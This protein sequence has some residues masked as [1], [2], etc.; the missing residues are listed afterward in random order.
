MR[1]PHLGL[2]SRISVKSTTRISCRSLWTKFS[3]TSEKKYR[4]PS[5]RLKVRD[6][7]RFNDLHVLNRLG[8]RKQ[9]AF[10]RLSD[11]YSLSTTKSRS[12]M[13]KSSDC[14]HERS[15]PQRRDSSNRDRP[16]NRDCF[17]GVEESESESPLSRVS[18]SG[19]SD[20]GHWKSKLKRHKPTDED[21]LALPW[22]WDPEDHEFFFQAAA[23]VERWAM[24]TWCHMFNSTLIG[25][26]RVWFDELP[27]ESIDGYKDLK[28]AFLSYFMQQKKYIK[29]PVEIH[30]I[31]QRDGETIK[32]FMERFKVEIYNIKQRD[33]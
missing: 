28:A 6:R 32:D 12:D 27:P 21:D 11:T 9:S 29:D 15:R 7:L 22:I 8:H 33:T 24:P 13:A 5:E 16:L 14:S 10:D 2:T 31:K 23:Q 3:V 25:D 30:K 17:C 26:A 19:T 18:E 1:M 20:G 4:N